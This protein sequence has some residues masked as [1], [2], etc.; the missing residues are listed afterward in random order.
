V[1]DNK[2]ERGRK[3]MEEKNKDME[4]VIGNGKDVHVLN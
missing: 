3:K 1:W 2:T 4:K